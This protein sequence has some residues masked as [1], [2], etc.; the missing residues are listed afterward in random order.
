[1][2]DQHV[3]CSAA[4]DDDRTYPQSPQVGR[5]VPSPPVED[6]VGAAQ[7][8]RREVFEPAV[9]LRET[10]PGSQQEQANWMQSRSKSQTRSV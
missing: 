3:D 2:G 4:I 8:V 1:M 5:R 7:L 6:R 9:N 10:R